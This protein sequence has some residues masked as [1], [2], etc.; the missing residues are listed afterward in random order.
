MTKQSIIVGYGGHGNVVKDI[1]KLKKRKILGFLDRDYKK[2]EIID[3]L[4][5]LGS[6]DVFLE[7]P[8]NFDEYDFYNG[9]GPSTK[10]KNREELQKKF[11]L[12]GI[13]FKT[14]IHPSAIISESAHI[15]E[16]VQIFANSVIQ[17]NTLIEEG[18]VINTSCNI[19]HDSRI[20]SN[21]HLAPAVTC[22]GNV[23]IGNNS[24][25]GLGTNILNNIEIGNNVI[26]SSGST[27]FKNIEDN[28]KII[29]KKI[30]KIE[31]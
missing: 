29:Q 7:Q 9:I 13:I 23:K 3:N 26:I 24:F 25:I 20:G 21:A 15:R 28:E 1:L 30:Y 17:P 5:C 14:I 16:G 6:D 27:I 11:E 10:N 18:T 2:G 19:D 22:G 12:K 4:E 8:I 31:K